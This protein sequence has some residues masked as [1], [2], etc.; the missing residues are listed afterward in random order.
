MAS[1]CRIPAIANETV[2]TSKISMERL[3][4]VC[5]PER[6]A[7][8]FTSDSTPITAVMIPVTFGSVSGSCNMTIAAMDVRTKLRRKIGALTLAEP[9]RRLVTK[10]KIPK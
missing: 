1:F 9:S 4:L 10:R 8:L 5:S 3:P 2:A 6:N 7:V